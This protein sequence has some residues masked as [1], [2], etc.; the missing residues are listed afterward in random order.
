MLE[1]SKLTQDEKRIINELTD[2]LINASERNNVNRAELF[3]RLSVLVE[4]VK[5][6]LI[7]NSPAISEG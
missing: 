7:S 5:L 4:G 6:G 2:K 1:K 3:G